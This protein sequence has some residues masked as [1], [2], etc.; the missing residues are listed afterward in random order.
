MCKHEGATV[1]L[2][3][4]DAVLRAELSVAHAGSRAVGVVAV[5]A[6]HC[7]FQNR[8]V[9][10]QFELGFDLLVALG[11]LAGGVFAYPVLGGSRG[12]ASQ[13]CDLGFVVGAAA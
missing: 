13:A 11:A 5:Y 12:V 7:P 4:F 6:A 9:I 3:A 8:M 10:G 1:L 2:V